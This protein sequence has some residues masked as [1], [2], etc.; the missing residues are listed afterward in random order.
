MT[1]KLISA[2]SYQ[3]GANLYGIVDMP[4]WYNKDTAVIFIAGFERFGYEQKWRLL[5]KELSA[6]WIPTIQFDFTWLWLSEGIYNN[7]IME[8]LLIDLQSILSISREQFWFDTFVLIGHSLWACV[9]L[10]AY[11]EFGNI[12][13]LILLAPALYQASLNR[14]WYATNINRSN[15]DLVIT[16]DN[17]KSYFNEN[18][19]QQY[20]SKP[21]IKKA[22]IIESTYLCDMSNM[23]YN[24]FIPNPSD[25][26]LIIHWDKDNTV[27]LSSIN[28][29]FKNQIIVTWWDHDLEKPIDIQQWLSQ[30]IWFI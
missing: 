10:S 9:A 18:E 26:L 11:K 13:K 8:N 22:N 24:E 28:H 7:P 6:V 5:S 27:P 3:K 20:I 30:T 14:Y 1:K 19:Y 16:W 17:Y 29:T 12:T 21:Q 25:N 23:N 2:P 15:K 4:D